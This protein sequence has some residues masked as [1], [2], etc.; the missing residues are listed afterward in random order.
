MCMLD[1]KF[2]RENKD[3]V[4]AGAKKKRVE[5][6]I[7]KLT[8][9]K[10]AIFDKKTLILVTDSV[11]TVEAE[12]PNVSVTVKT[13]EEL[14]QL[15]RKKNPDVLNVLKKGIVLFGEEHVVEIIKNCI[16]RF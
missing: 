12:I 5:I 1:I 4:Q 9:A 2:I 7:E 16:S 3:I 11:T 15:F 8:Q 10:A 14:M 13:E 6:D